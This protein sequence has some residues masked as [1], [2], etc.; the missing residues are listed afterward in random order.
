MTTRTSCWE[1]FSPSTVNSIIW[2]LDDRSKSWSLFSCELFHLP[3]GEK[4]AA[5]HEKLLIKLFCF[6]IISSDERRR[7]ASKKFAFHLPHVYFLLMNYDAV[8]QIVCSEGR[9]MRSWERGF[10]QKWKEICLSQSRASRSVHHGSENEWVE[11]S[12][13]MIESTWSGKSFVHHSNFEL[14]MD[15]NI[16]LEEFIF[17]V[18]KHHGCPLAMQFL[19]D[20]LTRSLIQQQKVFPLMSSGSQQII[21]YQKT[22]EKWN[23]ICKQHFPL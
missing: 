16:A 2:K 5:D 14:L 9:V 15:F 10:A 23:V 17:C 22:R 13:L 1:L 21:I 3:L 7:Q 19:T 11:R 18:L 12:D 8:R 20:S 6:S 4:G